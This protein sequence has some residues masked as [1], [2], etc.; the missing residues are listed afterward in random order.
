MQSGEFIGTRINKTHE[1]RN[2][3]SSWP[4]LE[5]GYVIKLES[6]LAKHKNPNDLL[7]YTSYLVPLQVIKMD[8]RVRE[9]SLA[10]LVMMGMINI[11]CY[12]YQS[13]KWDNIR[14][15]PFF[16][17]GC[18]LNGIMEQQTPTEWEKKVNTI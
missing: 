4:R 18:A 9:E 14:F 16:S 5:M 6:T 7:F 15:D 13:N 12:I 17:V 11:H 8:R 10:K 3:S 1:N 2:A